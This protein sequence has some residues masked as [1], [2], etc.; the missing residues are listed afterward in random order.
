[1]ASPYFRLRVRFRKGGD[2][3]FLSHLEVTRACERSARRAGLPYAVTQGFNPKMRVA[4]G[5]ALPV[6][7][8]G[9]SEYYDLRLTEHVPA[10]Q[11]LQS[12]AASSVGE[13]A[14]LRAGYVSESAPSLSAALT[15]ARYQAK[16][17]ATVGSRDLQEA[18]E[19]VIGTGELVTQRKGQKKVF[20]L[21]CALPK[22]PE[23]SSQR[24]GPV[25]ELTIRM[26]PAGS[27]RP[28]TLIRTALDRSG[29]PDTRILVT[30]TDL[31]AEQEDGWKRPLG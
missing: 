9:E 25:V 29:A 30:R 4:F 14:P 10:D 17:G 28:E 19:A 27:L 18:M 13:L 6:G 26:G 11:A 1:M 20:D 21:T 7:T 3:R 2:L 23:V 15:I 22:E 16:V 12:L 31:L 8:G 5:P 24:D